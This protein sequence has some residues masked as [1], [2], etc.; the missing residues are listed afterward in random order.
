M[1]SN[2]IEYTEVTNTEMMTDIN[3]FKFNP[4][5]IQRVILNKLAQT[6][7]GRVD[8]VDPTN[9]FVFLLDSIAYSTAAAIIES[10]SNLRKQYP[11]IAQSEEHIY[12]HM[13]D[14]DYINR[15]STP[16]TTRF[17]IMLNYQSLLQVMVDNP[18]QECR[19]ITIPRDS[20]INIAGTVF[21]IHYPIDIKL[22]YNNILQVSYN[23][24]I[25]HP[26]HRLQTNIID[27]EYRQDNDGVVWLDFKVDASQYRTKSTT[28]SVE[29]ST[30]F[31]KEIP[32]MDHFYYARVFHLKNGQW[33]EMNTTHTDQTFAY[34]R[35]TA[36]LKV[37]EDTL[38]V[39]IPPVYVR[40]NLI[41]SEVR[42]DIYSTLGEYNTNFAN[43]RIDD[44]QIIMD[45][46][47]EERDVT[48]Y[49]NATND[50]AGL[51]CF[52]TAVI[53]GGSKPL[54]FEEL[55]DRVIDNAFGDAK[56][57]ITNVQIEA[58]IETKG[59]DLVKN[60]DVLTNRIFL[61]TRYLP[62]PLNEDLITPASMTISTLTTSM[63]ALTDNPYVIRNYDRATIMSD[64]MYV[65]NNGIIDFYPKAALESIN[66]LVGSSLVDVVNQTKFMYS[67]FYYVLDN[68]LDEFELRAYHLDDPSLSGFSFVAQNPK[69]DLVVNTE[70]YGI[71]KVKEGY[72][73]SIQTKSSDIYK[74][75]DDRFVHC[76]LGFIPPGESK[77]AYLNGTITGKTSDGERVFEFLIRS[78]H[79]IDS[80]DRM[81]FTNFAMFTQ[82]QLL[83][84][85][86]LEQSFM[87]LYS[88]HS[89]PVDYTPDILDS[90]VGKFL[91]PA[92]TIAITRESITLS[93]GHRLKH[94]W[95][96]SRSALGGG[97]YAVYTTDIPLLYEEDVYEIDPITGSI[98]DSEMN[99][100]K[101]HSRGDPVLTDDGE[102][103]YQHRKGDIF[104]VD[105]KPIPVSEENTVRYVDMLF[106]DGTY[107][108]ASD[109]KY[110][111]Y[112]REVR[113]VVKEWVVETLDDVSEILLEQT[114]IY[115]Y[116]Y[117]SVG[118]VDVLISDDEVVKIDADQAFSIDLYVPSTIYQNSRVRAELERIV[119]LTLDEKIKQRTVSIS[120]ITS[121]LRS[122]FGGSVISFRLTGLGGDKNY[123]TVTMMGSS[124]SL[125]LRKQLVD[126]E[127]GTFYVR[128]AVKFNFIKYQEK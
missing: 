19:M 20:T 18:T 57:P 15:F 113:R 111:L 58:N 71:E 5:L 128:E 1:M 120:E 41:G 122:Q 26:L 94:L 24:D 29:L 76:Q 39:Y 46:I 74:K 108:F 96:Q 8:I 93:L 114:R 105:G 103:I 100:T 118:K 75:L 83:L 90:L 49:S 80:K 12:P 124:D 43:Y 35:P 69:S 64:A 87:I 121:I 42:V 23:N 81:A 85:T 77:Y 84:T 79:D 4:A 22:Y 55:K 112:M 21:T 50:L 109:E 62:K 54:T 9:P 102:P 67:P 104:L 86:D 110:Q 36:L 32:F 16:V 92:N 37:I 51:Y 30:P 2:L 73:L 99:Y 95:T 59:F 6:T 60:V 78:N 48:P 3:R 10:E 125:S 119:I 72:K 117:R 47:D 116:P 13:S 97:D 38:Q 68:S 65:V 52:S 106:I 28:F 107:R 17:N 127:D 7:D 45:P 89:V 40:S 27:H 53:S 33:V 126:L 25:T 66:N 14:R 98:F 123:E 115:F 11:I 63:E 56:L 34:N 88:T 70:F 44:F 101:L 82:E 31:S 61:A 91:L